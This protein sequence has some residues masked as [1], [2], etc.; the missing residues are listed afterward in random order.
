MRRKRFGY[1]KALNS[2][3][4]QQICERLEASYQKFFNKKGKPPRF[5]KVK[6]YKSFTF[7]QSGWKLLVWNENQQ[8]ANGRYRRA[9]GVIEIAG[10]RY[11]F[12]QHRPMNG[13][14]KTV[15]IKRDSLNRLWVC[16]SVVEKV[17]LPDEVSTSHVGGFDFGLKTFLTDN[18]GRAYI[19]PL[20]L[21][22][23][24]KRIRTLSKAISGKVEGSYNHTAAKSL[25]NRTHLRIV[26]ERRDF[27]FKLAQVLCDEYDVLVF[28]DLNLAGM[29]RLWGRKV[30][31]LAF[32]KFMHILKHMAF[33]RGKQVVVIDRFERTTGICSACRHKQT[34]ALHERTFR[35]E[36]CGLVLDRDH[37]AAIN[38]FYVGLVKYAGTSAYTSV[39]V[40]R[41]ASVGSPV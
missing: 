4:V 2:Q 24:L 19:H 8:K 15:M 21:T 28:E 11:K 5:K 35:C 20:F 37:N 25:L 40:V 3:A 6:R 30:S 17:S 16:F 10:N 12:I 9:R 33:K 13:V 29:K 32:G 23:A 36:A 14:V 38:I 34:I 27:H 31:D 39:G 41:P 18:Q 7:K 1:W 22:P 26:D